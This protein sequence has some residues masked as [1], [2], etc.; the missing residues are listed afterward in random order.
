MDI[1]IPK[2]V[3]PHE[4]RVGM[5]QNKKLY[6][7]FIIAIILAVPSFSSA[8]Q[9]RTESEIRTELF[10]KSVELIEK[11]EYKRAEEILLGFLHQLSESQTDE[12]V[13]AT[14]TSG[15]ESPS[16]EGYPWQ[17]RTHFLL[18]RLYERQGSFDRARYYYSKALHSYP[19][20]RNYTLRSLAEVY[21]HLG[22]FDR[23]VE[24]ARAIKSGPLLREARWLEIIVLLESQKQEAKKA[25][26]RYI[27]DF[28]KDDNAKFIL[29]RILKSEGEKTEAVKLLKE[30]YINAGPFSNAAF[31]ELKAMDADD[32]SVE[33]TVAMADSFLRTK[34]FSKAESLY[35]DALRKASAGPGPSGSVVDKTLRDR[36][37][38]LLG[39]CQ[40]RAKKYREA[41]QTFRGLAGPD[42]LFWKT[43][44][45]FRAKDKNGF[46][47]S[48]REFAIKYPDDRRLAI[49][50]VAQ[51]TGAR[52]SGRTNEA[53]KILR[54]VLQKFP[55]KAENALWTLGWLD[56]R[57]GKY[58]SAS[59]YFS[60]L[61]SDSRYIKNRS[62]Y[63][64]WKARSL[65]R[66]GENAKRV[67]ENL[68]MIAEDRG[69]YGFLARAHLGVRE[70]VSG[71]RPERPSRPKGEIYQRLYELQLLNMREEERREIALAIS[72]AE[73][74]EEFLYL[75]FV[76]MDAG[77]YRRVISIAER[78]PAK[79]L[80]HLA[81]PLGYWDD[82]RRAS[83]AKS[84][85]PYLVAAIIREE[86]RFDPLALSRAGA[87]GIMQI[88]PSTARRLN[89]KLGIEMRDVAE[90][91]RAEKNILLGV[92]Y[93]AALMAEFQKIPF[94]LA[95]YNAG[96][97]ALRRWLQR[98]NHKSMDEFIEDIP[99]A[100]TREYVKKVLKSYWQYRKMWDL[101]SDPEALMLF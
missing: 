4:C 58:K 6:F 10:K 79:G 84:L 28:P 27:K 1:G 26:Y 3:K 29:A 17:G 39:V 62:K 74:L 47:A 100:E 73:S 52:F 96:E 54:R 71:L 72:G 78:F 80:I 35:K 19:V 21:L 81:Y 86:S 83:E 101:P 48:L 97:G 94:A 30:L 57:E 68:R 22:D 23:A 44:S 88:M 31:E 99:F 87:M 37:V 77:D 82:I 13:S 34:N 2:K 20:V 50:L 60:I 93:F 76:A 70:M 90:L 75:G 59:K 36:I 12:S 40:F 9:E 46:E 18:G 65:E 14:D 42:A 69:Y 8:T 98:F 92:H 61:L 49:L 7:F 85:D 15:L 33:E 25:L 67:I 43:R 11:R 89:A 16:Q 45:L 66:S 95:A 32:L 24:N 38:F 56:Y 55:E 51:A 64:Y 63:I 53:R 91:Y 5:I 41:A